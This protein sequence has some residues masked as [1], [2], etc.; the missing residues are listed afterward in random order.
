MF[1][2]PSEAPHLLAEISAIAR[3]TDEHQI[4]SMAPAPSWAGVQQGAA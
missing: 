4:V 3:N 1:P 2:H